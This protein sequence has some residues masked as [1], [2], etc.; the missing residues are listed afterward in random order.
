MRVAVLDIGSNTI[1]LLVATRSSTGGVNTVHYAVEE[2]RLGSGLGATHPILAE[3]NMDRAVAAIGRLLALARSFAPAQ[4]Q[5]VATSAVRDAT[6]GAAFAARVLAATGEPVRILTGKE[7]ADY[8]GAGLAADPALAGTQ[9]F[10][11]FDLGG[12]SLECLEFR[13]RRAT[14]S[15]S[16]R[17]GCVRLTERCVADPT[18]PFT[19]AQRNAVVAAVRDAVAGGAFRFA[20]PSPAAAVATGGT[21]T[22]VRAI[23]SA[24]HGRSVAETGTTVG[25]EELEALLARI[26]PLTLAE[27][28]LVPGLPAARADIFPTALA[29][30][31]E[32]ARLA[33]LGRFTHSF[34]NL[35]YGIAT[36]VLGAPG[37]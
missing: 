2:A 12:G 14:Q 6:N 18:A 30:I 36:E 21:V 7:E 15:T 27:R 10:Y 23:I 17:L 1:K 8:I 37:T 33:G 32:V 4:T 19:A 31:I 24:E 29:T 20:L 25:V 35:R 34:Y 3:P 16:L 26:G 28:R 13:D 11:L 9:D 5:L 22:T